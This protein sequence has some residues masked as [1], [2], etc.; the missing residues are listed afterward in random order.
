[1]TMIDTTPGDDKERQA[2][3]IYVDETSKAETYFGVGAVFCRRDA[4]EE[5]KGFIDD[6]VV[7]DGQK[8]EKEIHWNEV[9][10]HLLPLYSEVGTQ[11]IGWTKPPKPKISYH[12]LMM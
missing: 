6:A 1:M 4:A 10:G 3:H 5:L 11:L 8:P 2:F 12:A 7:R 9:R